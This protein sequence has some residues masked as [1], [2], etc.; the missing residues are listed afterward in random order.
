MGDCS[1]RLRTITIKLLAHFLWLLF[2][3]FI[4]ILTIFW[5][6]SQIFSQDIKE[7]E[8]T[9]LQLL[10]R[11]FRFEEHFSRWFQVLLS[12]LNHF[13][14]LQPSSLYNSVKA[15]ECKVN[16]GLIKCSLFTGDLRDKV[17]RKVLRQI[18]VN[19]NIWNVQ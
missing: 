4:F 8:R 13:F 9:L 16:R 6:F 5:P 10:S 15:K 2:S 1:R 18:G 7:E 14:L 12:F 11:Y 3:I 17:N 19:G